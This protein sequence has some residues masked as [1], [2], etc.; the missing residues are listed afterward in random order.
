MT[1]SLWMTSMRIVLGAVLF[2]SMYFVS[3]WI[4]IVAAV[5]LAFVFKYYIEVILLG[6]LLD[7]MY[8]IGSQQAFVAWYT[9]IGCIGYGVVAFLR[10]RLSWYD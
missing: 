8:G 1:D 2:I 10:S 3:A 9:V 4:V 6:L 5:L 7:A